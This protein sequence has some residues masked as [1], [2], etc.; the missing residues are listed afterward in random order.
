MW[1]VSEEGV[2]ANVV[3]LRTRTGHGVLLPRDR[4]ARVY[5]SRPTRGHRSVATNVVGL[6]TR[7]DSGK[8]LSDQDNKTICHHGA[9]ESVSRV[10]L[11]GHTEAHRGVLLRTRTRSGKRNIHGLATNGIGSADVVGPLTILKREQKDATNRILVVVVVANNQ[12]HSRSRSHS[13]TMRSINS[14]SLFFV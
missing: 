14:F 13:L 1:L 7:T 5:L 8:G 4:L 10:Y 11:R 12:N 3:G 2:A 6:R 9:P